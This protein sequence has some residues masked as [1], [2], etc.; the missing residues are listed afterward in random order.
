MKYLE[1]GR[2]SQN[3]KAVFTFGWV[4]GASYIYANP[5]WGD[6]PVSCGVMKGIS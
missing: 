4:I 2:D 6:A 3:W 5:T 1:S